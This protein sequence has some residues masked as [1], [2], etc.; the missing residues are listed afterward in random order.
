MDAASQPLQALG[1]NLTFN[2]REV[3]L[4]QLVPG[5]GNPGL[6]Q[7]IVSENHEPLGVSIK[8]AGR[9]DAWYRD[10]ISQCRLSVRRSELSQ[11][12]KGLVE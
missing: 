5:V 6:K 1:C 3:A 7:A 8:T 11:H 4:W 10:E 2:L 9:V 12:A